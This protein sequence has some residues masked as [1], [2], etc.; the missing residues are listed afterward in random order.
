MKK[1]L[2]SILIVVTLCILSSNIGLFVNADTT[3]TNNLS[4]LWGYTE[5][6]DGTLTIT[7]YRGKEE[8]V[9]IPKQ[10]DGKDVTVIGQEAFCYNIYIRSLKLPNTLKEIKNG[11][12][13]N[14]PLEYVEISE[15]IELLGA[16]S[17]ANCKNLKTVVIFSSN[18]ELNVGCYPLELMPFANDTNLTIYYPK[19]SMTEEQLFLYDWSFSE[20]CNFIA[21]NDLIGDMN[22]DN[23]LTNMDLLLLKRYI[24]GNSYLTINAD[25]NQD[26]NI[27]IL[28]ILELKKIIEKG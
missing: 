8:K 2:L 3:D 20:N 10:I 24:L 4:D 26:G 19:N 28:D 15:S 11:A 16:Y 5:N 7:R 12:F 18:L 22:C 9:I 14:T 27:N 23:N 21:I 6:D 13:L 17:F 1:K 25:V